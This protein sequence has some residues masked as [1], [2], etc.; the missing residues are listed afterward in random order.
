MV[1]Y[2]VIGPRDLAKSAM[3]EGGWSKYLVYILGLD[4]DIK[5]PMIFVP[6]SRIISE[7]LEQTSTEISMYAGQK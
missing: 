1:D 5:Q 4:F 7:F 6:A 2:R 3:T